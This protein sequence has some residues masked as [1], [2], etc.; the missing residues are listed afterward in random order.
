MSRRLSSALILTALA[1]LLGCERERPRPAP[2][3]A[4]EVSVAVPIERQ[5]V[6]YEDFT[7]RTDAVYTVQIRPRVTGYLTKVAFKEGDIVKVNDLL[8]IV[9]PRPYQA[10]YDQALGDLQRLRGQQWLDDAQVARYERLVPKGA[11]S[12]QELDV[13]RGNQ[14][15]NRG[16]VKAAEAKVVAQKLNLDFCTIQ[17]PITGKIS[18]TFFQIGNL[19]NADATVLT[20]LVS[21]DPMYAYFNV[22]E[23]A[24]LRV[25]QRVREGELKHGK[26]EDIEVRMGLADDTE[27]KYPIRGYVNFLNNVVDALTGTITVRGVFPNAD[28]KL[29]PGLFARIRIYIGAP[30]KALLV[31]DRAIGTDQGQKYVYVID[32]EGKARYRRVSTGQLQDGLRVVDA[33]LKADEQIVVNGL[34]RVRPGIVVKAETVDMTNLARPGDAADNTGTQSVE[35][36]KSAPKGTTETA[37]SAAPAP[38]KRQ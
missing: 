20:T 13:Q 5:V 24:L 26:L 17:A 38:E 32:S 12:Q 8:Y 37:P 14:A 28:R 3:T 1:S 27:R 9:D 16:S 10:T 34:Q 2:S 15:E 7:G 25:Q 21:I 11:A 19:V 31:N 35:T 18:R 33:G 6:D 4:P 23:T 29:T 22:E 36:R 30:H